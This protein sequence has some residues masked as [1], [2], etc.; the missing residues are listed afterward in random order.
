[1]NLLKLKKILPYLFVNAIIVNFIM[2]YYTFSLS[3]SYGIFEDIIFAACL[4]YLLLIYKGNNKYLLFFKNNFMYNLVV[5]ILL[6]INS[7]SKI[8]LIVLFLKYDMVP[9]N[10]IGVIQALVNEF[11]LNMS[12]CVKD[13]SLKEVT[14]YN[15]PDAI[16]K[17]HLAC[18]SMAISS[19]VGLSTS[20]VLNSL[21][22]VKKLPVAVKAIPIGITTT[23]AFI[24]SYCVEYKRI[25]NIYPHQA[26]FN[27]VDPISVNNHALMPIFPLRNITLP[28]FQTVNDVIKYK[29]ENIVI[30]DGFKLSV[31]K[32]DEMVLQPVLV[33]MPDNVCVAIPCALP[34]IFMF[35]LYQFYLA[36]NLEPLMN[37][38][39]KYHN[40]SYLEVNKFMLCIH[41]SDVMSY[42][43][44]K[45]FMC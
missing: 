9:I 41:Q 44:F 20:F 43:C 28:D 10:N 35:E 40:L 19:S 11:I 34:D 6:L 3:S 8:I 30:L 29:Q 26:H 13:A 4:M 39:Y 5:G 1:M 31:L 27:V 18:N 33:T 21:P 24:S 45:L 22:I 42:E 15:K 38:L 2:A 25:C 17:A 23:A 16:E 7:L 36:H 12:E 14:I 32:I 37:F